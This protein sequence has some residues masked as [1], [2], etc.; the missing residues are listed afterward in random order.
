M[1][2]GVFLAFLA[3]AIEFEDEPEACPPLVSR[4]RLYESHEGTPAGAEVLRATEKPCYGPLG[5]G[6]KSSLC[7]PSPSWQL[8]VSVPM[9]YWPS[10]WNV[11]RRLN[12]NGSPPYVP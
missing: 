6:P 2:L 11:L 3:I 10:S 5:N 8:Y 12:T 9:T 7:G 4:P 1:V